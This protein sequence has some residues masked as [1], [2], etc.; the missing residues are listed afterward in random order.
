MYSFSCLLFTNAIV[1]ALEGL[2]PFPSRE[3]LPDALKNF[4][5]AQRS[6]LLHTLIDALPVS[7]QRPFGRKRL[8]CHAM[9]CHATAIVRHR[10][11]LKNGKR[12]A[13]V[14]VQSVTHSLENVPS[15]RLLSLISPPISPRGCQE[16]RIFGIGQMRRSGQ[17]QRRV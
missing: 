2:S 16:L 7:F 6:L 8:A 9:A 11:R 1:T 3:S 12:L 4:S 15:Q 17:S 5:L 14:S 10:A 13:V